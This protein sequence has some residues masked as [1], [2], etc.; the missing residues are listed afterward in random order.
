MKTTQSYIPCLQFL[1]ASMI[2]DQHAM[3]CC[4]FVDKLGCAADKFFSP[5]APTCNSFWRSFH[6]GFHFSLCFVMIFQLKFLVFMQFIFSFF[7][8]IDFSFS[9]PFVWWIDWTDGRLLRLDFS[10]VYSKSR[11]KSRA[12][13]FRFA[14]LPAK[15]HKTFLNLESSLTTFNN[16]THSAQRVSNRCN[17]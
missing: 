2:G 1:R 14:Q 3:L 7:L 17:D 10:F 6:L 5:A 8:I 4:C 9:L 13:K 15:S 16:F 11:L 12:V